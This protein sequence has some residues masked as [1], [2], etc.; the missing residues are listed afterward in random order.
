MTK[1]PLA[2]ARLAALCLLVT[3]ASYAAE[4]PA[5]IRQSGTLH[6]SVNAIYPPMEYKDPATGQLIGLDIDLGE[7]IAKKLGVKVEWQES[8]FEQLI[9]SLQTGRTDMI[10]SGLSDL[11]ARRETMDFIDYLK[12]GAQFYTVAAAPFE[13]PEDLCG[14]KVGTSRSTSFPAQIRA[15]STTNCEGA[16]KP[17]IE[18]VNAEST[19]D[20]RT[21]LKQGR[22]DAAVQGNE[23][24]P[25]FMGLESGVYKTVGAPFTVNYQGI[26]FKKTDSEFRD[27][28]ANTLQGLI[29]DGTYGQI[30]AK[31]KLSGNA[32]A[33]PLINGEPR[34]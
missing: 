7:A 17:A 25:Y 5:A 8:A 14:K 3:G 32:V 2:R 22:I 11:P 33:A 23:T 6:L 26:A 1:P 10:L 13:K 34:S 15:W 18:V 21:Q 16:G 28:V 12:S 31:W 30:L 19:A 24:V 20:A 29:I 9:P 4:L 27:L